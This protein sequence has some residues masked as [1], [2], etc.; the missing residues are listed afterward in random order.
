M[1]SCAR[2]PARPELN[3]RRRWRKGTRG[4][5][6]AAAPPSPPVPE[7][8]L[9]MRMRDERVPNI[10]YRALALSEAFEAPRSASSCEIKGRS[11]ATETRLW[12]I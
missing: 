5:A 3:V 12:E 1:G 7:K 8:S 11:R 6:P 9:P 10:M 2:D 4:P